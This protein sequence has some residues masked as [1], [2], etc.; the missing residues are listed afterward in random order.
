MSI[1]S[2]SKRNNALV[3]DDEAI[4]LTISAKM[5]EV[6]G[7]SVETATNGEEALAKWVTKR[8]PLIITDCHMLN[9]DGF[10]L[11]KA[12]RKIEHADNAAQSII[13]ALTANADE[14]EKNRCKQAGMNAFLT[15]PINL[16]KLN[17]MLSD[18]IVPVSSDQ[19]PA[20]LL[21]T[22]RKPDNHLS[23]V[24]Y[25]ILEQIFPDRAKQ[26]KI[27]Q[28]LQIHVHDIY[29]DLQHQI[30]QVNIAGVENAAHRMKGSCKM[31]GVNNIAHICNEIENDARSGHVVLDSALSA[32]SKSISQFDT[33]LF[34]QLNQTNSNTAHLKVD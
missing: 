4:S 5:V 3:V 16:A 25:A 21:D 32:L 20:T 9:M 18:Y 17:L 14:Q 29:H 13:I 7:W 2:K 23:P 30:E 22:M 34:Q 6:Q 24:D 15:K 33:Y 10:Q 8:H 28:D 19:E 27:L 12:I 1:I 26:I 11:T 31:V